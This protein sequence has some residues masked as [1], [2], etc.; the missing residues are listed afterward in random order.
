M[1]LRPLNVEQFAD[2]SILEPGKLTKRN[3]KL[4]VSKEDPEATP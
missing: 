1:R 2:W 3:E 4:L